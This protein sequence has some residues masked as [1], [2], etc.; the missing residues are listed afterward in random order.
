MKLLKVL[1]KLLPR[2]RKVCSDN[3]APKLSLPSAALEKKTKRGKDILSDVRSLS[4]PGCSPRHSFS[5][6]IDFE[7]LNQ[8]HIKSPTLDCALDDIFE[9]Q[10]SYDEPY[11]VQHVDKRLLTL[12][13]NNKVTLSTKRESQIGKQTWMFDSKGY[14]R[15]HSDNDVVLE[16]RNGQVQGGIVVTKTEE[17][18]E[19]DDIIEQN[20]NVTYINTSTGS[21]DKLINLGN[22]NKLIVGESKRVNG[23][24]VLHVVNKESSIQ[25]TWRMRKMTMSQ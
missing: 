17:R 7:E 9:G 21:E 19:D 15:S 24:L 1:K 2:R 5:R 22:N 20:F 10:I 25:C 14:I 12:C 6:E 23:K 3:N 4:S 11:H 18:S 16:V 8:V 13:D